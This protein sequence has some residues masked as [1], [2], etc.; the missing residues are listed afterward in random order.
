METRRSSSRTALTIGIA[1]AF[2]IA[3]AQGVAMAGHGYTMEQH[4][5]SGDPALSA[6]DAAAS[7]DTS[8]DADGQVTTEASSGDWEPGDSP[9]A[10]AS[11]DDRT[12]AQ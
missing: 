2:L 7:A 5:L 9:H 11:D 10:A 6:G 12:E 1:G 8:D 3:A 4:P